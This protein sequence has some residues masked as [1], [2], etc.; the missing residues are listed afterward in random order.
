MPA[1]PT[2]GSCCWALRFATTTEC[3]TGTSLP[4][5]WYHAC[6]AYRRMPRHRDLKP[7][8]LLI[9]REGELKLADFGLAR[10]FGIPVRRYA[11]TGRGCVG[12]VCGN[13]DTFDCAQ[14]YPRGGNPVVSVAGRVAGFTVGV[15]CVVCPFLCSPAPLTLAPCGP[16]GIYRNYSTPVDLWSVGCIF[17]GASTPCHVGLEC[18]AVSCS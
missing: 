2:C 16:L 14:L 13:A 9:N 10:A 15:A 12:M 18:C 1:S 17:A 6:R 11:S 5:C 3:C 8:N 7:Q 4:P